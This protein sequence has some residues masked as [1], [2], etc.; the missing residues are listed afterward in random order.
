MTVTAFDRN[1][2]FGVEIEFTDLSEREIM[3]LVRKLTASG[4]PT[5]YEGYNHQLRTTWKIVT[6]ASVRNPK[7]RCGF[8][9]VSPPLKGTEGLEQVRTA[10]KVLSKAGAKINRSC[11]L[12]IHHDASWWTVKEFKNVY[13]LYSRMEATLDEA[14]PRSRRGSNNYY[15]MSNRAVL[16]SRLDQ[17]EAIKTIEGLRDFWGSRYYKV[18]M[19][20]WW[21][22]G[23]I[24]FRH[25]SGTIEADKI[26]NWIVFTQLI[27]NRAE[28]SRKLKVNLDD[29]RY[30]RTN[31]WRLVAVEFALH[32]KGEQM[33]EL[34]KSAIEWIAGRITHFRTLEAAA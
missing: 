19:E 11:G 31:P 7:Y 15:C 28:S 21:R 25:H 6:D 14:M 30:K 4:I 10:L 23:T 13:R 27:V 5:R 1:R 17:F 8:E 2:T 24:E 33:D 3:D 16:A 12:H 34:V 9:L 22:H 18:N 29:R 26:I 32:N 20:S